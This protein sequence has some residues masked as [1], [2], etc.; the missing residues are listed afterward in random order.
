MAYR[1]VWKGLAAEIKFRQPFKPFGV[2]VL[3]CRQV[4]HGTCL[5]V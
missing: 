3:V 1:V 2:V 5:I 4:R